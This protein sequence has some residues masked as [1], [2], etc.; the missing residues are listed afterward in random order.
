MQS[1]ND[2]ALNLG[3]LSSR[4]FTARHNNYIQRLSQARAMQAKNLAQPALNPVTNNSSLI[5]TPRYDQSQSAVCLTG[6][7]DQNE[8]GP[9]MQTP[10]ST[11]NALKISLIP[12]SKG[13]RVSLVSDSVPYAEF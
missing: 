11:L 1:L 8:Q 7:T 12:Y 2:L 10:P 9:G 5:D 13:A 6:F 3:K 4:C